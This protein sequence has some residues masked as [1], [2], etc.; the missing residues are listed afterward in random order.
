MTSSAKNVDEYL[1]EIP[2]G[3]VAACTRIRELC[4][5]YLTELREDMSY[6]MPCYMPHAGGEA[7]VAWSSQKQN[8][9]LYI[10]KTNVL[11]KYRHHFPKSAIGKGC[12]RYRKPDKIDFDLVEQMIRDSA[13]IPGEIC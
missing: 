7:P 9:A 10:L 13:E 6:G 11:D 1:A 8:I 12:I 3:R 4:L 5:K 2:A